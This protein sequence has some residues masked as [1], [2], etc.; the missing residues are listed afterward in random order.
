MNKSVLIAMSGGVDSS[1]AAWLLMQEGWL[2][3]GAVMR[4]QTD[5]CGSQKDVQEGG[6]VGALLGIPF[7]VLDIHDNLQ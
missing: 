2:C 7:E 1:V 3:Q 6:Q 4:L 5:D